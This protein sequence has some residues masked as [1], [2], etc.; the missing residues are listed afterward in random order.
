M[1]CCS[2]DGWKVFIPDISEWTINSTAFTDSV[3]VANDKL[4]N[5]T[6]TIGSRKKTK[7]DR[8]LLAFLRKEHVLT[9]IPTN[10]HQIQSQTF[11]PRPAIISGTWKDQ[12]DD[13]PRQLLSTT[14]GCCYCSSYLEVRAATSSDLLSCRRVSLRNSAVIDSTRFFHARYLHH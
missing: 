8:K 7:I 13:I 2:V 3:L 9:L 14:S 4:Q 12:A 1:G 11:S 10:N 5:T 6:V